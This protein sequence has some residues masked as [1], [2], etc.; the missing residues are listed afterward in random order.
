MKT[1]APLDEQSTYNGF[2]VGIA[3]DA[4]IQSGQPEIKTESQRLR[5]IAE[6]I[7]ARREY[8]TFMEVARAMIVLASLQDR[9]SL[10]A[11]AELLGISRQT[12]H[13]WLNVDLPGW[14]DF[15]EKRLN[16]RT[17]VPWRQIEPKKQRFSDADWQWIAGRVALCIQT[18]SWELK[19]RAVRN[20]ARHEP[21]RAHLMNIDRA[22]LWR[23]RELIARLK[24]AH[25]AARMP[26]VSVEG[27]QAA[28]VLP[29]I[30]ASVAGD[31]GFCEYRR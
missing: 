26:S 11:A 12:R 3:I 29:T 1:V 22:T 7:I 8:L 25:E 4:Q 28:S 27:P 23:A 14:A 9:K 18:E 2:H 6:K 24:L 20:A 16:L 30:C 15:W 17:P 13:N 5:G 21:T 10:L 31:L 19:A